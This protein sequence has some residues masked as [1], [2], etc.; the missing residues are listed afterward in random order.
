MKQSV[1]ERTPEWC[2]RNRRLLWESPSPSSPHPTWNQVAFVSRTFDFRVGF[3]KGDW[4]EK[5]TKRF[6]TDSCG[7]SLLSAQGRLSSFSFP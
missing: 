2:K 4:K 1:W 5:K 3:L 7:I 6:D